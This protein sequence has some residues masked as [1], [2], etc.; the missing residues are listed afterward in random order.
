MLLALLSPALRA[1]MGRPRAAVRLSATATTVEEQIVDVA[2]Y[3]DESLALVVAELQTICSTCLVGITPHAQDMTFLGLEDFVCSDF[4]SSAGSQYYPPRDCA[5]EDAA[6]AAYPSSDSAPCCRNATLTRASVA[7]MTEE[8]AYGIT[9]LPLATLLAGG[10]D[11]SYDS[12]EYFVQFYAQR[13]RF[14]VQLIVSRAQRM[15]ATAYHAKL[16]ADTPHR[17]EP[18]PVRQLLGALMRAPPDALLGALHSDARRGRLVSMLAATAEGGDAE[19]VALSR[20]C[21]LAAAAALPQCSADA[22]A[23]NGKAQPT[24]LQRE[25]RRESEQGPFRVAMGKSHVDGARKEGVVAT[26]KVAQRVQS[27]ELVDVRCILGGE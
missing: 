24:E 8:L 5:A 18:P 15:A 3:L 9:H 2:S 4:H 12:T 17:I 16:E 11:P 10:S 1:P 7:M 25:V 6:W 13:R 26:G 20:G 14:I 27:E 21:L 19:G 23:R 22:A